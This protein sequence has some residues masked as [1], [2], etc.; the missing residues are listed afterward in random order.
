MTEERVG[1]IGLGSIGLPMARTLQRKGYQVTVVGHQRREPVEA[2]KRDGA[3]EANSPRELA[4]ECQI[5]FS[6][7]WNREQ[8]EEVVFGSNGL[9]QE[10]GADHTLI[11]CSTLTPDFCSELAKRA[12]NEK[13]VEVLDA[14]VSGMP[15]GAEAGTLT[16]MVGGSEAAYQ[17]CRRF[18][19]AMGKNIFYTGK[20]GTG[21][22]AKLVNQLMFI[23]NANAA[24][25]G[26]SLANKAGLDTH[27][28]LEIA[29]VSTGDSWAMHNYDNLIQLFKNLS[30]THLSPYSKDLI[31]AL[32]F[33]GR[34]SLHLPIAGLVAQLEIKLPE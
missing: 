4:K 30:K 32:E 18:F 11:L 33:A 14:P 26:L 25:E 10:L 5:I 15:W 1:W 23:I 8:T 19:E 24:L 3:K 12:K 28:M 6:M 9:W 29:K 34:N 17:R 16:F 21:Q 2:M 7:V 22:A 13:A 27:T 20:S 31:Y